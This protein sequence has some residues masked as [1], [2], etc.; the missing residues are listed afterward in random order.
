METYH[1]EK[2]AELKRE[3]DT[4]ERELGIKIKIEGRKVTI[5][6]PSLNE[7]TADLVIQAIQFGFSAKT[8]L[9][10]KHDNISFRTLNI[11]DYTRRKNLREVLG[12]LIGTRGQTKK[13]IEDISRCKMMIKEK[14]VAVIGDSEQIEYAVTAISNLVKGSKQSN[15]YKYLE[16]INTNKKIKNKK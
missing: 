16:K 15:V 11:K 5:E 10:L 2:I 14:E 3:K 1:L 6:G 7:Y 8:A 12:R 4:I 13:T 9:L